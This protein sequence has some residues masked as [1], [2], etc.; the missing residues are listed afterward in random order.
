MTIQEMMYTA[1]HA[2]WFWTSGWPVAVGSESIA[3]NITSGHISSVDISKSVSMAYPMESKLATSGL[4]HQR[5][6]SSPLSS[7]NVPTQSTL[8]PIVSSLQ[9]PRRP[10]R[11][12]MPKR[13]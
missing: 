2:F 13:P 6:F 8:A 9:W 4:P 10:M 1:I 7:V 5:A 11:N 3:R 12:V